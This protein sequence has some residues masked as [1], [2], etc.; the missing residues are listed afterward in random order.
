[1]A[2]LAWVPARVRAIDPRVVDA[3]MAMLLALFVF[4]PVLSAPA[5]AIDGR[6]PLDLGGI[7]LGVLATAPVMMRRRRPLTALLLTLVGVAGWGL[8][9]YPGTLLGS[10]AVVATYS[11]AAYGSQRR[12]LGLLLGPL[13]L[14]LMHARQ[15]S[16]QYD[17]VQF[18]FDL[19]VFSTG[20]FLGDAVRTVR[21]HAAELSERAQQLEATRLRDAR[22]AVLDERLRIA[23]DL[24]D[25]VAH[26]MSVIAVHAGVGAHVAHSQPAEAT[27]ALST[28]ETTSRAVMQEMRHMLGVL[29][30]GD[31]G[32][33]RT[34]SPTLD[35][36]P[37]LVEGF[38]VP[39]L[40]AS[41]VITGNPRPLPPGLEVTVYRIGQEALTN[42]LKHAGA[43]VALV[44]LAYGAQSLQ[45]EV[46]DD[47]RGIALPREETA[48]GHGMIGMIERVAA[49]GGHLDIESGTGQ[50]LRLCATFPCPPP[51]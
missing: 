4:L 14:S 35:G 23:R 6:R 25:V 41:L 43:R 51:A 19:V 50:G 11:L 22:Q 32:W 48:K 18:A 12:E 8:L 46:V 3:S 1:M 45:L 21:I 16:G 5:T 26:S 39:G 15:T 2:A 31:G 38:S 13:V 49:F 34:P 27:K 40:R 20:W 44:R 10:G 36:L 28:I 17:V 30:D 42:V 37:A 47:G 33:E 29:R 24:H 7:S 9:A